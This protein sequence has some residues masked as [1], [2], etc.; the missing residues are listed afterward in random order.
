MNIVVFGA[1]GSIGRHL[2]PQALARGHRLTVFGR[3][4][5]RLPD[6]GPRG[7]TVVGDVMDDGAVRE[8]VHD[9]DAVVV[10]L[11]APPSSRRGVRGRGTASILRA[12]AAEGVTR[13]VCTSCLGVGDSYAAQDWFTRVVVLDLWLWRVVADHRVQE[14]LLEQT[15]LDW[16]IVRPPHLSDARDGRVQTFEAK[17]RSPRRSVGRAD[18]AGWLLDEVE[19]PRFPQQHI[20]VCAA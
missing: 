19:T 11:G 13:I 3:S 1:S 2:V 14:A 20:G 7:R 8:A 15:S 10:A 9:A 18:L 4:A 16:T 5:D 6:P 12:M 17:G